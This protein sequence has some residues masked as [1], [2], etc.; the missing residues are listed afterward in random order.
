LHFYCYFFLSCVI[1]L[2]FEF[3]AVLKIFWRV[4]NSRAADRR[5]NSRIFPQDA[6]NECQDIMEGLAPSETKEETM[7][8]GVR[9][10]DKEH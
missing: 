2:K 1:G 4:Q 9:A 8:N 7:Y 10:G 3:Q 5:E 6:K